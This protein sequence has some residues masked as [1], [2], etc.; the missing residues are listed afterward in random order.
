MIAKNSLPGK[1]IIQILKIKSF[2]DKQKLR[3]FSMGVP[4]MAQW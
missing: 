3:K 2:T 1:V 4:I